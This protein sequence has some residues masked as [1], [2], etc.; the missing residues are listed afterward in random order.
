MVW[1]IPFFTAVKTI[2]KIRM[3]KYAKN[4]LEKK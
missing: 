1:W 4:K 2:L 3:S